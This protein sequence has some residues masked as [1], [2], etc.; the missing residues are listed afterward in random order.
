MQI[1]QTWMLS[2]SGKISDIVAIIS[3]IFFIIFAFAGNMC[4]E[5]GEAQ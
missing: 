2:N 1:I 4:L 3:I 5:E